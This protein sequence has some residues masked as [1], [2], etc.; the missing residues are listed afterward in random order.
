MQV[1][2]WKISRKQKQHIVQEE[3]VSRINKAKQNKEGRNFTYLDGTETL[4][5]ICHRWSKTPVFL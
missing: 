2:Y 3:H 5:K 4:N 1:K